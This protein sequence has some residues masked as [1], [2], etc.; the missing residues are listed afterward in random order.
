MKI[1]YSNKKAE[2]IRSL[3]ASGNL[4]AKVAH[5][6]GQ[7]T[8][9]KLTSTI[10]EDIK[11][12]GGFS[13]YVI[14]DNGKAHIETVN[15]SINLGDWLVTNLIDGNQNSYIIRDE[16]FTS[17]YN[18]TSQSDIYTP[19]D[20]QRTVYPLPKNMHVEIE[21]PWGSKMKVR[22]GGVL[23]AEGDKFYGINPEEFKATYAFVDK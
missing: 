14:D 17:V 4:V 21:A 5:K 15:K 10:I 8:A 16:K 23:I 1:Q 20:E 22:G 6:T 7:V 11:K 2:D 12:Q 9:T 13:T 18:S 3:I 19:V